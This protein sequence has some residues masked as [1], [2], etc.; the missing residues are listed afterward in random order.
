MESYRTKLIRLLIVAV[1]LAV[2][3]PFVAAGFAGLLV[4]VGV[5][6]LMVVLFFVVWLV[7]VG[8][9]ALLDCVED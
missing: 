8:L 9:E 6:G 5:A 3:G 2:A 1:V 7:L 4:L